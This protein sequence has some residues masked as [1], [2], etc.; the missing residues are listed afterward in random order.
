MDKKDK[1]IQ[2]LKSKIEEL[3]NLLLDEDYFCCEKCDKFKKA[4][5]VYNINEETICEICKN[6]I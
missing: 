1:E 5:E 6:K 2:Y 4:D 3:Q